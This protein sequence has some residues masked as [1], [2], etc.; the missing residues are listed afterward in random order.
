MTLSTFAIARRIMLQMFRDKRT[1][2]LVVVV[3]LLIATLVGVS[4]P[5]KELLNYTAP[6]II[7]TLILFFGFLLTGIFPAG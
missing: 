6:A 3:P 4:V 5:Q 7:A 1:I 2:A